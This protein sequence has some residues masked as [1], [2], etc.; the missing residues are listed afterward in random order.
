[1]RLATRDTGT[2]DGELLVVS[3]DASRALPA[4]NWPNLLAAITDWDAAEGELRVVAARIADG[5]GEPLDRS[6]LRAPLPRTWQWL[7]GSAFQ[8]HADLMQ[9][10]F[11]TAPIE[12]DKPLMYQ[13]MSDRFYG[14]TEPVPFRS[15]ADSIDFEGEFGVVVDAVPI[16]TSAREA[17]R[18]IKLVVQLNDWSLRALAVPEM[19]TGFGWI[20]AKP[21]CSMAPFAVTPASLGDAWCDGRVC[22]DLVVEWNGV[23]FGRANGREMAFGFQEL[24]AHAAATRDLV[25]GTVIGSGTVANADYAAVGSSCISE[26]RAIEIIADGQPATSFMRFGDRCRMEARTADAQAFFGA[27]EQTVVQARTPAGTR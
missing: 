16:G 6:Q 8:V 9:V 25:A 18:H 19:K 23:P 14:P 5:A 2:P 17:V 11:G 3:S 15:E 22:L 1:M 24:V 7:D 10:A 13:G 12:H 26:R 21:A 20:Q 4:R 27:I